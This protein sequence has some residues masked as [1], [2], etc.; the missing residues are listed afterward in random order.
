MP[1]RVL[2]VDDSLL[3]HKKIA[4]ALRGS[5]F[6]LVATA[7]NGQEGVERYAELSPDVVL[8][9]IV[10]PQLSGKDALK[11]I[12]ERNPAARVIMV[13]SLGTEETVTE[14]LTLGALRFVQK[15]FESSELLEAL[16]QVLD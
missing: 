14:C 4:S 12:L 10:M 1:Y 9:D 8:L 15:P 2:S 16:R 7:R 13:S 5:E 3:M 11:K 6:E